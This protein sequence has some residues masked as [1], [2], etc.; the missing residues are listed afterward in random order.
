M[1]PDTLTTLL[2]AYRDAVLHAD[3]TAQ[4]T[5]RES[6]VRPVRLYESSL[7]RLKQANDEVEAARAA[8]EEHCAAI[9]E[10]KRDL[11]ADSAYYVESRARFEEQIQSLIAEVAEYKRIHVE[12]RDQQGLEIENAALRKALS[13]LQEWHRGE[14]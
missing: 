11:I 3:A 4:S 13:D 12:L 6:T 10:E 7:Q 9:D 5:D 1:T 14:Y 8:I 2:D